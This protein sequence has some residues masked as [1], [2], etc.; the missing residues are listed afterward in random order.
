MHE[1]DRNAPRDC[2]ELR[3]DPRIERIAQVV[4]ARPVLEQ[5]AENVER[6]GGGRYIAQEGGES[7][8]RRRALGSQVQVGDEGGEGQGLTA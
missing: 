7:L 8:R 4:V 1:V 6:I 3:R 2:R 5:V